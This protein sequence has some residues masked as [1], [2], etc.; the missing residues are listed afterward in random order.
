M[1]SEDTTAALKA[2]SQEQNAVAFETLFD[3]FL[4]TTLPPGTC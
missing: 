2:G 3:P 4:R 1:R